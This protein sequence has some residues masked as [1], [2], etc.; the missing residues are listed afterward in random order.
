MNIAS[1]SSSCS[2]CINYIKR[3]SCSSIGVGISVA[4]I[5]RVPTY[6]DHLYK[7]GSIIPFLIFTPVLVNKSFSK[8]SARSIPLVGIPIKTRLFR[9]FTFSIISELKRSFFQALLQLV[10]KLFCFIGHNL[11]IN[12]CVQYFHKL[13]KANYIEYKLLKSSF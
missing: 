6:F 4:F 1:C 3:I 5:K 13:A 12:K 2:P 10:V 9:F 11:P 7:V 8:T